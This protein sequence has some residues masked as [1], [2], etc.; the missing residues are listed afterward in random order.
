MTMLKNFLFR[1]ISVIF[2]FALVLLI[3]EVVFRIFPTNEGLRTL[4]VNMENPIIRFEENRDFTW[5]KGRYF[6]IVTRKHSNNYGFLNDED[7]DKENK[8]PLLAVIGDSYVEACQVKNKEAMHGIRS[9]RFDGRARIYSFGASGA[10]LSTYLAYAEYAKHNFQPNAMIFIIVGNDFDES[11]WKY[12]QAPGSYYFFSTS[13]IENPYELK[14]VDYHPSFIKRIG[15]RS[16][17]FRY[18][19]LNLQWNWRSIEQNFSDASEMERYIGNTA[20]DTTKER[21]TDSMSAVD[22]FFRQLPKRSA[23]DSSEI[24]FVIDGMRPSLYSDTDLAE[25]EK[26]YFSVMRNYFI[27]NAAQRG[28]EIIDMQPVF[29]NHYKKNSLRFE[30]EID[31]HW[32][33]LGHKLVAKQIE[34]SSV[35]KKA[36]SQNRD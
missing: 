6:S 23:L 30:F 32:N 10:Q 15:R 19:C 3:L 20:A 33:Q 12:K 34:K 24:L 4:P 28:Y 27:N 17:I 14:R 35:V 5:S 2:G 9:E 25:A 36:F 22:E 13:D 29:I 21:L 16:A 1:M 18:V 11:L 26:C 7:Y 8:Y 31:G